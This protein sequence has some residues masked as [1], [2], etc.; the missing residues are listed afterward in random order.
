MS[1]VK[2]LSLRNIDIMLPAREE[3]PMRQ[4]RL[5]LIRAAYIL[6]GLVLLYQIWCGAYFF[7]RLLGGETYFM[8][9]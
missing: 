2:W 4:V 8:M 7:F 5:V 3:K 1:L 9:G 6:A